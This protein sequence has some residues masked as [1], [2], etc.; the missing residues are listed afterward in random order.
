M[1]V[2]V[3]GASTLQR[4][5]GKCFILVPQKLAIENWLVETETS[6]I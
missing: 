2:F 5:E 4:R 6:G 1:S 3:G